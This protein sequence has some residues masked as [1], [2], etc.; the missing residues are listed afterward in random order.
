MKIIF[1]MGGADMDRDER[2]EL[3]KLREAVEAHGCLLREIIKILVREEGLQ[4]AF[5]VGV[6]T[7]QADIEE[8]KMANA[9]IKMTDT[10]QVVLGP[11]TYTDKRGNP[12]PAPAGAQPPQWSVDNPAFLTITPT[13]DGMSATL[14]AVGPLGTG[15]VSVKVNDASGAA[16]ASGA[17]DVTVTGGAPTQVAI[18]VGAPSEQP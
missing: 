8:T 9:Q 11:I 1:N 17:G 7:E 10:Q 13:P 16:L 4:I 5:H 14:A 6:P 3:R 18:P 15:T 12:T 2:R